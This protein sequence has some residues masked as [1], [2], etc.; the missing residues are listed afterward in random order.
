VCDTDAPV[1]VPLS[2]KSQE[3]VSVSAPGSVAVADIVMGTPSVPP[4]AVTE[5]MVGATLAIEE[6]PTSTSKA[7]SSSVTVTATG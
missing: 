7:P 5:V 2:P 1:P 6:V 3:Y 4:G